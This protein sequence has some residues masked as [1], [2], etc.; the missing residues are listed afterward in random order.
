[1]RILALALLSTAAW[2]Q[3]NPLSQVLLARYN[4]VKQNLIE[5]AEAMPEVDYA[6]KL[7]PA[8]RNFGAWIEHTAAG[9]FSS[10]AG[11]KGV[12][13]E[14]HAMESKAKADLQKMLQE[15]FAFCDEAFNSMDDQKALAA[16]NGKYPVTAMVGLVAGLNEHYGNLV[17][18]LRT[19]GITPP[20][21]ARAA[22]K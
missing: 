18:Y 12:K 16:V 10:C 21:T 5:T 19:K 14:A 3:S 22:K 7:S 11:I 8:Q 1:M 2:A 13:P 4:A 9:N 20:S 6:Y 15:S 17:G